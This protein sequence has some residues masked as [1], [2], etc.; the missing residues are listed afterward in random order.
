MA[1]KV[2]RTWVKVRGKDKVFQL[3]RQMAEREPPRIGIDMDIVSEQEALAIIAR[4]NT[5]KKQAALDRRHGA[6]SKALMEA[7]Q[8]QVKVELEAQKRKA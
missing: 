1:L 4:A 2:L 3:T 7:E 8:N 6:V 5:A